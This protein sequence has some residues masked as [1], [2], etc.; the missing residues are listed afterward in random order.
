MSRAAQEPPARDQEPTRF[1]EILAQLLRA[2][3][4]TL[5]AALADPEGETVDYAGNMD[6][7]DLKVTAAHWQIVRSELA[8]LGVAEGSRQLV[9]RARGRAYLVRMLAE[10]YVVVLVMHPHAAFAVSP[11]I[12]EPWLAELALEAGWIQRLPRRDWYGVTV[13]ASSGD[14][15][16]P[17]RLQM[18]G[19]WHRV[20]VLGRVLGL[21]KAER[22]Y[23]VRLPNGAEL[24]LLRERFGGWFADE[25]TS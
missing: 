13:E 6:P 12:L 16:R 11:R 9:V 5:A 1:T 19:R 10:G 24:T 20:E 7:F 4:G 15:R 3:P 8:G 22:G 2:V 23:R 25:A 18:Q 21:H 17:Q 14:H